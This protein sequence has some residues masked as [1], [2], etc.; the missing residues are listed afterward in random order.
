MTVLKWVLAAGLLGFDLYA[1]WLGLHPHVAPAWRAY[2]ITHTIE[3]DA[4]AAEL[5]KTHPRHDS[6]ADLPALH[7]IGPVGSL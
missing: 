4:F 3:T 7:Q 5:R 2:Y 6:P 1:L